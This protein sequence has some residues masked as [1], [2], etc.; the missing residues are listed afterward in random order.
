MLSVVAL[1]EIPG[2]DK[3]LEILPF[4]PGFEIEVPFREASS[5]FSHGDDT[6]GGSGS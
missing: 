2:S 1:S 6:C 5:H 4:S 3:P